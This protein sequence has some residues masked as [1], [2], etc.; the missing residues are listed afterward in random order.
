MGP[1]TTVVPPPVEASVTLGT[2][3][4]GL[5]ATA[6]DAAPDPPPAPE[7][8]PEPV[9]EPLEAPDPEVKP[10]DGEPEDAPA[11][12]IAPVAPDTPLALADG[13]P[14][15]GAPAEI[16]DS[17]AREPPAGP[18]D[19]HPPKNTAAR[20]RTRGQQKRP[21]MKIFAA[22]GTGARVSGFSGIVVELVAQARPGDPSTLLVP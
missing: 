6:P 9:A 18:A 4:S 1:S 11:D 13:L 19:E 3:P 20:T 22:E 15:D 2:P 21:L 7:P 12:A 10:L 17:E 8:A 14:E 5:D 16:P